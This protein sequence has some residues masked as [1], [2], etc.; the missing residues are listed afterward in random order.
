MANAKGKQV[1]PLVIEQKPSPAKEKPVEVQFS[2]NLFLLGQ[3]LSEASLMVQVAKLHYCSER[4][5]LDQRNPLK[6]NGQ[7]HPYRRSG[8][9]HWDK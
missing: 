7:A 9:P 4:Q 1:K 3:T 6:N 2:I 8:D 5:A